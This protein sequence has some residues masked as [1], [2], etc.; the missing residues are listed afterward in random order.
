MLGRW[1]KRIVDQA[2]DVP[3]IIFFFMISCRILCKNTFNL[4]VY[5]FKKNTK[6]KVKSFECP[7][8]IKSLKRIILGTSDAWSTIRLSNRPSDPAWIYLRLTDFLLKRPFYIEPKPEN[9]QNI[10]VSSVEQQE[11]HSPFCDRYFAL[12]KSH[13]LMKVDG[14]SR[15]FNHSIY[16]DS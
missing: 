8:S 10:L 3:S 1:D 16:W 5:F 6:I 7:K 15:S 9:I 12:L 2:S 11:H 4:F 14:N 13:I